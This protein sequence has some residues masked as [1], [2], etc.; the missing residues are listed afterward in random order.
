[1]Q[2]VADIL[3][4]PEG[5]LERRDHW[6][7]TSHSLLVAALLH[8][9]LAEANKTL[10]G[11]A[12]FLSDPSRPIERTL[13]IMMRTRH[14]GDSPHDVVASTAREVL[15]KAE[16]ERSGVLST[17]LGLYRDPVVAK[18]T[19]RC[20]WRIRNAIARPFCISSCRHQTLVAPGLCCV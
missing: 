18:V 7:K 6:E 16:N 5:A 17:D 19:V 1:V 20:D 3:V 4:D 15:N 9:L 2:N 12:T 14:L 11:V 8:V 13:Q 10:A